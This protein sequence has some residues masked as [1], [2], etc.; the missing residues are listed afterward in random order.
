M[1]GTI[2][3]FVLVTGYTILVQ[4]GYAQTSNQ[5]NIAVGIAGKE[6][7]GVNGVGVVNIYNGTSGQLLRIINSPESRFSGQFGEFIKFSDNKLAVGAS[8]VENDDHRIGAV[9]VFDATTG[10][11]LYTIKNPETNPYVSESGSPVQYLSAS[12]G[13]SIAFVG[14]N[15][16]V[17]APGKTGVGA[18]YVFDGITGNLLKTISDPVPKEWDGFGNSIHSFKEKIIVGVPYR[19]VDNFENAGAVS[20]FDVTTGYEVLTI[21]NPEPSS[22]G[23]FGSSIG[24][25]GDKI[26]V[27]SPRKPFDGKENSGAVYIFD[28]TNGSLLH[29]INNPDP[30]DD[31]Y[32]GHSITSFDDKIAVGSRGAGYLMAGTVYT[33]DVN[34]GDL[35]EKI[36]NPEALSHGGFGSSLESSGNKLIVGAPGRFV[37]PN[38]D[39]GAVYILDG[40]SGSLLQKINDA[41]STV[42]DT[43]GSSVTFVGNV[44][45]DYTLLARSSEPLIV[46]ASNNSQNDTLSEQ[47]KKTQQ[48]IVPSEEVT[49]PSENNNA[50]GPTVT[51]RIDSPLKQSRSGISIQDIS[52]KENLQLVFKWKDGSPACVKPQTLRK[53]VERGWG[54]TSFLEKTWVEIDPIQ[55]GGNPWEKEWL[56]SHPDDFSIYAR[57]ITNEKIELIKN[58]YK[59]QDIEI[60]DVKS[61]TWEDVAV[62][63]SCSC[64]AGYTLSLLVS[65]SDV[66]KMLELGYK[67]SKNQG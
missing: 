45:P 26:I 16:I 24:T 19:E 22:L 9:Y 27:G 42:T 66:D 59:K 28:G 64:S 4:E 13:S 11:L 58:Y 29:T 37:P 47:T 3:V 35:L 10:S 5:N 55:C 33:F 51:A 43:F 41:S 60:F 34:T 38:A 56:E 2:L 8:G 31:D 7:G 39:S 32:F 14:N 67:I 30:D 15:I 6:V 40:P 49:K 54:R 65:T 23:I 17:A 46:N 20:V 50:L 18:V 12:F 61:F 53:L 36:D 44:L 63:E 57:L 62:C 25:L 1:S 48:N 21:N 52:C